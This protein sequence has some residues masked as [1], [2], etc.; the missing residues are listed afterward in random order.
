MITVACSGSKVNWNT[1]NL[2]S[3]PSPFHLSHNLG[4]IM[5][6][7]MGLFSFSLSAFTDLFQ[8]RDGVVQKLLK[9]SGLCSP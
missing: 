3:L 5:Q 4:F 7:F 8:G 1:R 2:G 6:L 9:A